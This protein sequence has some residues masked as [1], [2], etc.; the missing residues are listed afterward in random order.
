MCQLSEVNQLPTN[1]GQTDLA[2]FDGTTSYVNSAG[3]TLAPTHNPPGGLGVTFSGSG[4]LL[5]LGP[6]PKRSTYSITAVNGGSRLQL[7]STEM[8]TGQT[9]PV[10]DEIIDFQAQYGLDNGINNGS[11]AHSTFV[12]DDG[13]LDQFVD[14]LPANPT[15][16]DWSRVLAVRVALL[17]RSALPEKADAATG[18]CNATS[19]IPTWGT[20]TQFTNISTDWR[21]YR[22][23]VLETIVPMR[24]VIWKQ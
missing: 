19:A 1:P 3:A 15:T 6:T 9:T 12:A 18:I 17:A 4:A 16:N 10:A 24:N 2:I 21:C 8:F 7:A 14:G 13:I 5:N 20:G 23:R 22:Y 11:V